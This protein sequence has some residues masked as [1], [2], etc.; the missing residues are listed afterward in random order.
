M[1]F[2]KTFILIRRNFH[3][4]I[5]AVD[6]I[7]PHLNAFAA[8]HNITAQRPESFLLII[9]GFNIPVWTLFSDTCGIQAV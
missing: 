4:A 6:K 8:M 7:N 9:A 5:T 1:V 3:G 2:G